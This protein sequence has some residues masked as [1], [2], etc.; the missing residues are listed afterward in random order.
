MSLDQ[1]LIGGVC[2]LMSP[3]MAFGSRAR[4]FLPNESYDT[5]GHN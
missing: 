5:N 4:Q 1:S 2:K 3:L